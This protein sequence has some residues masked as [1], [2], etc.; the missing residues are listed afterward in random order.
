MFHVVPF[1]TERFAVVA[2]AAQRDVNVRVIGIEVRYG[3]PFEV[4]IEIPF[5]ALYQAACQLHQVYLVSKLRR[6]DEFP[7]PFIAGELPLVETSGDV[8]PSIFRVKPVRSAKSSHNAKSRY[9][10]VL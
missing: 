10:N 8:D 4:G 1:K 2:N 7:H 3:N 5:H 6:H 9:G